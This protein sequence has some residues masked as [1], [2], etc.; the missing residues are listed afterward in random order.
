MTPQH[1]HR[2][3]LRQH[4]LPHGSREVKLGKLRNTRHVKGLK[5]LYG[6]CGPASDCIAPHTLANVPF[7]LTHDPHAMLSRSNGWAIC[8]ERG[9]VCRIGVDGSQMA[10]RGDKRSATR[11]AERWELEA[12]DLREG[13]IDPRAQR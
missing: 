12:A 9:T 2:T 11:M 5:H 13:R 8:V 4:V 3:E 10:V 7:G 6:M 1:Y